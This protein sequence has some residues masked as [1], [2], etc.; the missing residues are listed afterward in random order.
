MRS[1]Q[2]SIV[3]IEKGKV[4]RVFVEAGRDPNTGKRK[5]I[6]RQVRGTRKE[7]ERVK[8]ELLIKAGEGTTERM[9]LND[10][11][12]FFYLPDCQKRL[13]ATTVQGYENHYRVHI[14]DSLGCYFLDRITPVVVNTWLSDIDGQARKYEALKLLRQIL[15]KAVRWDFLASNPCSKVDM[16]K[17][18]KYRPDVL[19]AEDSIEYIKAYSGTDIE[20]GVLVAIGAGLRRSEIVALN[21]GDITTDGAITIDD[22]VTSVGGRANNDIP[23]T[24]FSFRCVHL[25]SSIAN[26]L[27]DLRG[28]D[29]QPIL[30]DSNG[31]RLNPDNFSK[32]Y[33]DIQKQLP[34]DVSR[35]PLKNLRHTSLTLALESGAELLAVS[36]RAGHSNVGITAAFY[37]RPHEAMDRAAADSLDRLFS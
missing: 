3:E 17:K 28:P 22:A 18:Q 24:S 20:A 32:R 2:A 31:N 26:R 8:L 37:L 29:S 15:N 13:R 5:R 14:K 4:Y 7:A 33:R 6:S 21:W 36:R 19:T 12:E 10:F 35:I 23:K 1:A 9:L 25:P 11:W 30:L 27:N 34:K 16:P